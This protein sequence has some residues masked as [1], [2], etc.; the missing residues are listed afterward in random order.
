MSP[1]S[2]NA[3]SPFTVR[4]TL[5]WLATKLW[6]ELFWP[7]RRF[8]IGLGTAWLVI[9]ALNLTAGQTSKVAVNKTARPSRE[10]LMAVREQRQLLIQLLD[11]GVSASTPPPASMKPRGE[12]RETVMLG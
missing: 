11:S 3:Q 4:E 10:T 2:S 5:S 12:L 1:I 8:W 7:C 6:Q 9:L